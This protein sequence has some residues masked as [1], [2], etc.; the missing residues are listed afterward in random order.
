MEL[1]AQSGLLFSSSRQVVGI[2]GSLD[3]IAHDSARRPEDPPQ[4]ISRM[5]TLE[6]EQ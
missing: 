6:Y 3:I 4:T 2:H 5:I 1:F